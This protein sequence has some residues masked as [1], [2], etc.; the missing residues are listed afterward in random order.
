MY[1]LAL[2]LHLVGV[3]LLVAAVSTTLVAML[4]AQRAAAVGEV[5]SLTAVTKKIDLVI[6]PATLLILASGLYMVARADG[7]PWASGWVVVSLID[8]VLMSILGPT[9]E[10]GHGRRLLRLA[11]E[12]PEG[13]VP[14]E[15]DAARRAPAGIYT[16]FFGASQIFA[17]LY[18]MT[19]KPGL[20]ESL[21]ACVVAGVLSAFLAAARLR[22]LGATPAAS[23][24][25]EQVS[26]PD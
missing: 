1:D 15:L 19:N 24:P 5:A 13:P 9:V 16:S 7:I 6:G 4:R 2:F 26:A 14:P 10:A 20:L 3:A 8:F 25:P 18:V 23:V 17:F 11:A 22:A 12:L 21:A